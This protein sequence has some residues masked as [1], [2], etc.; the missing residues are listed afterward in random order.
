LVSFAI[1][2]IAIYFSVTGWVALFPTAMLGVTL[3]FG[4]IETGKLIAA[5]FLHWHWKDLPFMLKA[6]LT[7]MVAIA[8]LITSVG[9]YGFLSKGHLDQSLPSNNAALQIELIDTR[10]AIENN[11]IDRAKSRISSN[12]ERIDGLQSIIDTLVSFDRINDN[13]N[14]KGALTIET[15]QKPERDLIRANIDQAQNDIEDAS[16]SISEFQLDRLGYS[17]AVNAVEAKLGPMQYVMDILNFNSQDSAVQLVILVVMFVF[18]PFAI[19]LLLAGLWAFKQR[20][21]RKEAARLPV[22]PINDPTPIP[23]PAT[24]TTVEV[25]E[26][27]S[28]STLTSHTPDIINDD[29]IPKKS[30]GWIG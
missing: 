21:N 15:E 17:Q 22:L 26:V 16:I 29:N 8:M 6:S 20:A 25:D 19:A 11:N 7:S 9:V 24:K 4:A 18:D 2:A 14:G 5:A 13:R 27:N 30:S 1:S 3:M 12:E 23:T 10:I 28:V